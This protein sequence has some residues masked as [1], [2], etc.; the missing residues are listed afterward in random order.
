MAGMQ[1]IAKQLRDNVSKERPG[2]PPSCLTL[3]SGFTLYYAH[4]APPY[5]PGTDYGL[6]RPPGTMPQ[7]PAAFPPPPPPPNPAFLSPRGPGFAPYTHPSRAVYSQSPVMYSV[8]GQSHRQFTG[9]P[10]MYYQQ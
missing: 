4:E 9:G 1:I 2:G 8:A 7:N 10:P 3:L 5:L 6:P